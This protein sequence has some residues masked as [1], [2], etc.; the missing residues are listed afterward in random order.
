[1]TLGRTF[2]HLI[3]NICDD[4]TKDGPPRLYFAMK[5]LINMQQKSELHCSSPKL[6]LQSELVKKITETAQSDTSKLLM[7][8]VRTNYGWANE[9]YERIFGIKEIRDIQNKVLDAESEFVSTTAKRKVCQER[10]DKLK[11]SIKELWDKIE[12]TGRSSESYIHLRTL[13]HEMVREQLNLELDLNKLKEIEQQSF[14]ILSRLLRRSHELERLRQER[15]KYWHLISLAIGVVASVINIGPKLRNQDR[16]LESIERSVRDL[17]HADELGLQKVETKSDIILNSLGDLKKQ[18]RQLSIQKQ[19]QKQQIIQ[20]SD[21]EMASSWSY[22]M[23][24]VPGYST[25]TSILGYFF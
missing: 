22:Y 23:S 8:K 17:K 15:S 24:Y 11:N 2:P 13:E 6:N 12:S 4:T 16:K 14:D 19:Q 10:I 18:I 25:M 21:H 20:A 3:R 9:H 5:P 1:M 7:E